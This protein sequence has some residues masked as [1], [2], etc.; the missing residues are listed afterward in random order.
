[1]VVSLKELRLILSAASY[2]CPMLPT[3]PPG[4]R[5]APPRCLGGGET[6]SA[7]H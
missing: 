3:H 4:F 2:P 7:F 1:M 6:L 5:R